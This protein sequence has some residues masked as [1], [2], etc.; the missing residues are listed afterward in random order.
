[1]KKSLKN[2]IVIYYVANWLYK[3]HIPL[4]PK[5]LEFL[6]FITCN[7][8]LP[9]ETVIKPG[10]MLGHN[11]IGIVIHPKVKIGKNVL[12]CQQVTIGGTGYELSVPVIGDDVYIGAGAKILGPIEIGSNC[13]IGANAVVVKSVPSGC[14]VAGVPARI[15]KQGID[16]HQIENW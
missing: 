16:A 11:G 3:H 14:V 9:Y 10:C 1:M 8:V 15:L 4:L 13:V 7:V 6:L 2:S 5:I 12:I